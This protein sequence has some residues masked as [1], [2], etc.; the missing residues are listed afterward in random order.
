MPLA[1]AS[2]D[3]SGC[4]LTVLAGHS[5]HRYDGVE[6]TESQTEVSVSVRARHPGGVCTAILLFS[7]VTVLLDEPLSARTIV[8]GYDDQRVPLVVTDLRERGPYPGAPWTWRR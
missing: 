5:C 1:Q 3:D 6:V 8:D 2:V 7:S 4:V